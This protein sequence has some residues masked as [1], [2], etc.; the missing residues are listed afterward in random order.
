MSRSTFKGKLNFVK[1]K[2]IGKYIIAIVCYAMKTEIEDIL[3]LY[4]L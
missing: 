1:N 2:I 4:G 3:N